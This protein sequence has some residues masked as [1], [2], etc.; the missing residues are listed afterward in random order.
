MITRRSLTLS[1]PAIL[2]AP[3]ALAAARRY[4]LEPTA[5]RVG[6]SFVLN[7]ATL[8]GEMP[9]ARADIRVDTRDLVA[10]S[11][12]VVLDAAK[13]RT[14]LILATDVMKGPEV[15]D[16]ARHPY[17]RFVSRRIRLGTGGRISDGASMTGDLTLRGVTRP[18]TLDAALY[19]QP[20]TAPADL[21][22][23]DVQLTGQI[24]RSA[25]GASGYAGLVADQ[26]QLEIRARI[27]AD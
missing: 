7:D 22:V 6:F 11:V 8:R 16:T 5:S 15:L 18:V 20:G 19:R 4:V 3:A 12:E 10:S 26:V 1:L 9:V 21:T 23:L 17:I 27:R 25:F 2:A 14:G 24:S 13:A